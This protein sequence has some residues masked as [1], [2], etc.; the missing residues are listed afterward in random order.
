MAKT[1]K[2]WHFLR[3]NGSFCYSLEKQKPKAGEVERVKSTTKRPLELCEM[4]LHGSVDILDALDFAQ[5]ALL[6]R[7]ELGGEIL[8]GKNK[9]CATERRELWRMDVTNILHEFSCWCAERALECERKRG[10]EPDKRS[11]A[12][13]EAKRQW[14]KGEIDDKALA[15]AWAAAW[16]AARRVQRRK[17]L[18]MIRKAGGTI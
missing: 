14:L 8:E 1:I 13:I 6:R 17:L 11:W 12:A 5:G 4:G 7:V 15:A 16:D 9:C 18:T 2:A 3:D 10:R